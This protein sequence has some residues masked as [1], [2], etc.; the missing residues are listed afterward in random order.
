MLNGDDAIGKIAKITR[1][2]REGGRPVS[3]K[4]VMTVPW[5][6]LLNSK[7]SMAEE[8]KGIIYAT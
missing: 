8:F 5:G 2:V 7:H 3:T 4:I 6:M 1:N